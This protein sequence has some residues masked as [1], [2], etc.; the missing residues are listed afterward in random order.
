MDKKKV[1]HVITRIIVGGA[2]YTVMYSSALSNSSKYD[3]SILTGPQ[4]GPEGSIED[5]IRKRKIPLK[6]IPELVR[7]I[8]PVKDFLAFCKMYLYIKISKN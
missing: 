8:N 6:I 4:T 2:Q 7:E 5:E 1:L 3:A